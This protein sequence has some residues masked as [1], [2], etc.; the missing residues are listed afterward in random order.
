[1]PVKKKAKKEADHTVYVFQPAEAPATCFQPFLCGLP[2][3]TL[4]GFIGKL[5]TSALPQSIVDRMAG[6]ADSLPLETWLQ[7]VGPAAPPEL[8]W[9]LV[10]F[11]YRFQGLSV[12]F[13]ALPLLTQY[14]FQEKRAVCRLPH[15]FL[16]PETAH[17]ASETCMCCNAPVG[18]TLECGRQHACYNLTCYRAEMLMTGPL[19]W[20]GAAQWP[21]AAWP[22]LLQLQGYSVFGLLGGKLAGRLEEVTTTQSDRDFAVSIDVL[23]PFLYFMFFDRAVAVDGKGKFRWSACAADRENLQHL[24]GDQWWHHFPLSRATGSDVPYTRVVFETK[25]GHAVPVVFEL[26]QHVNIRV[27]PRMVVYTMTAAGRQSPNLRD[28][29]SADLLVKTWWSIT[30]RGKISRS[31]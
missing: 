5:P 31:N 16:G 1:M 29:F 15:D 2:T 18:P 4:T 23:D 19:C 30:I 26:Q 14:G 28:S 10:F 7:V 22:P 21:P 17:D 25:D 24:L 3:V 9:L 6:R 12:V 20:A 11:D 13:L 27:D 8:G